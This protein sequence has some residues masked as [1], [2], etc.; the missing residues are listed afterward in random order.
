MKNKSV[1]WVDHQ[2]EQCKK[3]KL[4]LDKKVLFHSTSESFLESVSNKYADIPSGSLIY[5]QDSLKQNL[6]TITS[7]LVKIHSI[8]DSY[9]DRI[10]FIARA[11][12]TIG[13]E[14]ITADNYNCTATSLTETSIC[15]VAFTDDSIISNTTIS[16]NILSN[17]QK[18]MT[19]QIRCLTSFNTGS[20]HQR[21]VKLMDFLHSSFQEDLRREELSTNIAFQQSKSSLLYMPKLQSVASIIG[22]SKENCSRILVKLKKDLGVVK[23]SFVDL[24]GKDTYAQINLEIL[25]EE[26]DKI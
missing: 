24:S 2:K 25:K 5:N 26:L 14:I 23:S 7:G 6:F 10:L 16:K 21:L 17:W 22:T 1:S 19:E 20:T 12:M 18:I 15:K 4:R 8:D 11:P 13:L 3:C 9:N